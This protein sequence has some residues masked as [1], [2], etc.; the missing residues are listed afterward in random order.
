MLGGLALK[1]R[2]QHAPPGGRQARRPAQPGDGRQRAGLLGEVLP[3]TGRSSRA[4]SRWRATGFHLDADE[5]V[6]AV[7]REHHRRRRRSSAPPSTAATSRSPRSAPRSTSSS[8]APA[9]TSRSTSTAPPARW[10][11]RSSTRTWC[12]TSGC[13]GWRRST[14][15]ATSTAWST[16]ASAGWCGATPTALPED[17]VFHVNYLGGD[18][19]TFALNFSRP[20]APGRRAVLQLPAARAR[21]ATGA[22]SRPPGTWPRCLADAIA[23]AGRRSG[24]SPDGDE[25]PVFAFTTGRRRR[26]ASTSSTSPRR[27]ASAAGWC[28]RT[29]SRRTARTW[30][31]CASSCR[32]GFSHDLA[33]VLLADLRRGP[34]PA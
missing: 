20:G 4:W 5:A 2:W 32:N 24:C 7:R 17:L 19:P 3:T 21:R 30:P 26:A 25:L 12:G 23:D 14:P 28:P 15:R 6:A 31:C 27:C 1:R 9:S 22:C 34:S 11:R 33:D 13:R 18:M 8:S 10:S 29:P 16:R